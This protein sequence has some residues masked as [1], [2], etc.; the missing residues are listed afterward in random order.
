MMRL[1]RS[2]YAS[3]AMTW[4]MALPAAAYAAT[5]EHASVW[6]HASAFA[7]Y[8]IG[9]LIC[10]QLPQRSFHLWGAQL[11]V[12]A[13]CTGIYCGAAIVALAAAARVSA[14]SRR[15]F[16][17]VRG[18]R[19]D[20]VRG[21]RRHASPEDAARVRRLVILAA[22]P[23]LATLAY[24]WMTGIVP[25]NGIRFAAGLPLGCVVSWLVLRVN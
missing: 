4:L 8:T 1:L 23:T 11:P 12:C 15:G 16:D 6:L 13:R 18:V 14:S 25:S 19:L 3:A 20:A 17:A 22:T 7:V 2:V 21:V 24:E 9:S 5:R 10:H